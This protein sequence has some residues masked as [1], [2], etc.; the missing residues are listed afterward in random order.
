MKLYPFYGLDVLNFGNGCQTEMREET[1][2]LGLYW[3]AGKDVLRYNIHLLLLCQITKR[4]VL[5]DISRIFDPSRLLSPSIIK[6]KIILQKL[7]AEKIVV[8]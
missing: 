3:S 2:T 5:S 6:A 1:T 8:G 4:T 7:W